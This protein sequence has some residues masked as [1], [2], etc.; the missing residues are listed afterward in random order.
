MQE[1]GPEA[2]PM[3]SASDKDLAPAFEKMCL[4][5]TVHLFEFTRDFSGVECPFEDNFDKLRAQHEDLRE[6]RFLEEVYGYE[7]HLPYKAWC[8]I[9]QKK[10][11]WVLESEDLRVAV[12]KQ[13]GIKYE[14]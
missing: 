11:K 8:E 5:A 12:F 3:I 6:D 7:S 13:A 4:L 14:L 2:N 9:V 1:G 10:S